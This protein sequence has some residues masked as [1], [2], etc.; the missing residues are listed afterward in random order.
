MM[1]KKYLVSTVRK[2]KGLE[3]DAII[4]IDITSKTFKKG[5]EKNL[6]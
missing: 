5:S 4:L 3:A 2:F 1:E 6:N